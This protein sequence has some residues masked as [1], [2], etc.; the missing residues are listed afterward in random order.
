MRSILCLKQYSNLLKFYSQCKC[1]RVTFNQIWG[2]WKF[3]HV[4]MNPIK[5]CESFVWRRIQIS[6]L[7]CFL[8]WLNS[9]I[10]PLIYKLELYCW[11][12]VK[13][14]IHEMS[15]RDN[16]FKHYNKEKHQN[17]FF[18]TINNRE[19]VFS[20][21]LRKCLQSIL[22]VKDFNNKENWIFKK[23][24]NYSWLKNWW[25]KNWWIKLRIADKRYQR[26]LIITHAIH[27]VR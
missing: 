14:T 7:P 16:P 17:V 11:K 24:R 3:I 20:M 22:T 25:L 10:H 9:R 6:W 21:D 12:R 8:V 1:L 23:T 26:V 19:R 18:H 5:K 2:L 15:C 27:F 4:K 13:N